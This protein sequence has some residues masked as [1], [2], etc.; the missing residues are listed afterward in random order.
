MVKISSRKEVISY[1]KR[2]LLDELYSASIYRKLA[3]M[4]KRKSIIDKLLHMVQ[5]EAKHA[6]F[7]MEFLSRRGIDVS[8]I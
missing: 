7:W 1:A 3:S 4:Y 2:M 6:R 8:G 5:M